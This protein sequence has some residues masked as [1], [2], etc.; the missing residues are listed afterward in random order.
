MGRMSSRQAQ[1][2]ALLAGNGALVVFTAD[3]MRTYIHDLDLPG[4]GAM[5][6]LAVTQLLG[7]HHAYRALEHADEGGQKFAGHE[8]AARLMFAG[9][10][11]VGLGGVA[12]LGIARGL[13]GG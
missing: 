6:L 1:A 13:F 10:A 7:L 5:G 8:R 11:C 4:A 3:M 9:L 12:V 2:I